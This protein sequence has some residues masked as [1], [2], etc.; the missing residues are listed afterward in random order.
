MGNALRS[1]PFAPAVPCHRVVRGGAGRATLGGFYGSA[2]RSGAAALQ[3]KVAML[4]AEGVAFDA[5]LRLVT[6]PALLSGAQMDAAAVRD[7]RS[8][9]RPGVT[10]G[11][12]R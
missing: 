11:K 9:M 6:L 5:Q 7:A 3:R 4:G 1:N 12:K 2:E 8:L 10:R